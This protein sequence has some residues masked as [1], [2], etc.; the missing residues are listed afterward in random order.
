MNYPDKE[1]LIDMSLHTFEGH[2][3]DLQAKLPDMT[4]DQRRAFIGICARIA[5]M[6]EKAAA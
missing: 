5:G 2:L 4:E 1:A 3:A 6:E